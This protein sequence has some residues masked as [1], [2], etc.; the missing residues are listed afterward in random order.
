[1]KL[2]LMRKKL[3][4]VWWLSYLFIGRVYKLVHNK[5]FY[6][7]LIMHYNQ[8]ILKFV[9]CQIIG[10]LIDGSYNTIT[11]K[12]MLHLTNYF[13]NYRFNRAP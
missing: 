10:S 13:L 8:H 2:K 11:L 9:N 3:K 4:F 12:F 7:L 6:F 1:M 5:S